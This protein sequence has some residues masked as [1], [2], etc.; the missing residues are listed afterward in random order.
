MRRAFRGSN[1]HNV[2]GSNRH[3]Q[4]FG[5]GEDLR[6]L[7]VFSG[8][9]SERQSLLVIRWKLQVFFQRNIDGLDESARREIIERQLRHA[10]AR[11][12]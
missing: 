6:H 12:D 1:G 10:R 5:C 9:R 11:E 3:G 4:P 8:V 2:G 7:A